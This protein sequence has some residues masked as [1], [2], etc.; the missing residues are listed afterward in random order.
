[1]K[2]NEV[3]NEA[4]FLKSIGKGLADIVAP[5]AYDK[6]R[7]D[8]AVSSASKGG[9]VE[10]Q[11]LKYR[12]LGNQWGVVNPDTDKVS[13][14]GKDMQN[15]LNFWAQ[16]NPASQ[17]KQQQ[18]NTA[19]GQ[20]GPPK[21]DKVIDLNGHDYQWAN[22]QWT[23]DNGKAITNPADIQTLNKAA[24]TADKKDNDVPTSNIPQGEAQSPA[25]LVDRLLKL[26]PDW[27]PEVAKQI[28]NRSQVSG[29]K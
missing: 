12:W 5:G 19:V 21:T 7:R 11:G 17:Q 8:L 15:R 23:I 18:S 29:N 28:L 25:D 27:A 2:I 16:R 3:I 26:H 20:Y 1:M 13:P 10:Y 24:Y 14:A 6:S 4:G 9:D 22:G